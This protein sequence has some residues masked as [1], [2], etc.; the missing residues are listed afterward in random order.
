M[1]RPFAH[2][3]GV[4][5]VPPMRILRVRHAS[6]EEMAELAR[7]AATKLTRAQIAQRMGRSAS[8]VRCHIL[9][10]GARQ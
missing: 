7:L 10:M 9:R 1:N 4:N 6:A 8:W 3:P 5:Y 2:I